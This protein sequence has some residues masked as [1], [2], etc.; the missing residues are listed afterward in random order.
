MKIAILISTL[1]LLCTACI[2]QRAVMTSDG[3]ATVQV[4][5]PI[6]QVVQDYGKPY[7]ITSKGN[8]VYIYEYIE[9]I[10]REV[11]IVEQR[12]YFLVVENG[13][14]SGKY[15]KVSNPPPFEAIY[16][17]DPYPNY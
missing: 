11:K 5:M 16:S 14:V 3:Y 10:T 13:K 17:D 6:E 4:G 8:N 15:L 9:R 1:L 7:S 2:T 12:R